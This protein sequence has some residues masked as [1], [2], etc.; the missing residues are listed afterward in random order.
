MQVFEQGWARLTPGTPL[1]RGRPSRGRSTRS[2]PGGLSI[3]E[4]Q[5]IWRI[6]TSAQSAIEVQLLPTPQGERRLR[7]DETGT[8]TGAL[9]SLRVD[10]ARAVAQAVLEACEVASA[11]A[12]QSTGQPT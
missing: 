10:V 7:V 1:P 12:R 8:P 9:Q 5:R 6:S 11:L 2:R 3:A 4:V